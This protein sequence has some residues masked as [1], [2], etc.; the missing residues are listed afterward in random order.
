MIYFIA[1]LKIVAVILCYNAILIAIRCIK[2][3]RNEAKILSNLMDEEE[4]K[5]LFG[6]YRSPGKTKK[7]TLVTPP[8]VKKQMPKIKINSN[9]IMFI[10][11]LPIIIF[12]C[13]SIFK[14]I[15]NKEWI[16]DNYGFT[17]IY[18]DA[19]KCPGNKL[20]VEVTNTSRNRDLLRGYYS[21]SYMKTGHSLQKYQDG[22][23]D[24]I[25]PP[26][27]TKVVECHSL[28]ILDTVEDLNIKLTDNQHYHHED[29]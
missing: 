28:S 15:K 12:G 21:F 18:V 7:K 3:A 24:L 10:G 25:V 17:R 11:I 26:G 20:V 16:D 27:K 6:P 1:I 14:L 13:H 4:K 8:R 5:G 23:Y 19:A 29:Y 2:R 9:Y 22:N